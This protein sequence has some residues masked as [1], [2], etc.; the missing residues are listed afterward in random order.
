M[1]KKPFSRPRRSAIIPK[2][3]PVVTPGWYK[4]FRQLASQANQS[5]KLKP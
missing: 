5:I 4:R 2:H 3:K 1:M